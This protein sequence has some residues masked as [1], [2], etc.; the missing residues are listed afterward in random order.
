MQPFVIALLSLAAIAVA[1]GHAVMW[2][3]DPRAALGW[4]GLILLLPVAG[5]ALYAVF[6]INRLSRK[7]QA[8]YARHDSHPVKIRDSSAHAGP[9]LKEKLEQLGLTELDAVVSRSVPAVARELL[10]GNLVQ[11][12]QSGADAYG[13]MLRAIGDA[14]R[15]VTLCTYIFDHDPAGQRFLDALR[16]ATARGVQV[17]VL[18]DALGDRYTFPSMLG[19][20]ERAGV[21]TAVFLPTLWPA[22]MVYANL[23]NHRKLLVVDGELAFTGGM[24]IRQGHVMVDGAEGAERYPPIVDLHFRIEGPV[25][26]E[27]Q[28]IFC[29]DW[30]FTTGETLHSDD[31]FPILERRGGVLARA[32]D[33]G[34]GRSLSRLRWVKLGALACA[35]SRVRIATPY[36]LPDEGLLTGLVTAARRGVDVEVLI[37][38]KNNLLMVQWACEAML[39]QLLDGGVTIRKVAPPFDH[40]KLMVVDDAWTLLGSA[41]WD[42]R[43]LRLNFELDVECYDRELARALSALLDD[44]V[45]RSRVVTLEEVDSRSVPV[46]LRD[47]LARLA[48]PYL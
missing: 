24:N 11:P 39:W 22:H 21:T 35:H 15:S 27:L 16:D 23:R 20:L 5:A 28:A 47:G 41:N 48:T 25:V 38:E 34:P 40:T 6:G 32:L 43:S 2:K 12:L 33:D 30:A 3:R 31:F 10:G 13:A 1:G 45:S 18:I 36:F 37:P 19:R 8:L 29:D 4:L 44:K 7:A 17:R 42:A 46:R 9:A 14:R 26:A